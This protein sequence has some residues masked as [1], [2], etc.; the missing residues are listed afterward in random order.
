[1]R[2]ERERLGPQ[3]PHLQTEMTMA[4]SHQE[5]ADERTWQMC[6]AC[7]QRVLRKVGGGED[8]LGCDWLAVVFIS[9]TRT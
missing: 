8:Q 7:A 1:M 4:A 3:F 6:R 5:W 2:R 9:R